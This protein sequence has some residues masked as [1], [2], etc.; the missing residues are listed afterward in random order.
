MALK[1]TGVPGVLFRE[2]KT[3]KHGVKKDR[4]FVIYYRF[5][6]KNYQEAVGWGSQG[7]N[8]KKA[9]DLLGDLKR[10]QR[11][12]ETPFTLRE[13]KDQV[14]N[15]EIEKETEALSV[16]SL[17]KRYYL[18]QAK[19]DKKTWSKDEQLF[20]LWIAPVIG[21]K[22]LH[23]VTSFDIERIKSRMSKESKSPKTI[24][25]ALAT[26]RQ[27]F[28]YAIRNELYVGKN[29]VSLVKKP[30][31]DNRRLRFLT[32]GEAL[33]LLDAVKG[34]SQQT[35]EVALLS[36]HTGGRF[37]EI[38]GLRWKDIDIPSKTITFVDTKNGES[39]VTFMT[40]EVVGVLAAKEEGKPSDL[41]FPSRVGS[42]MVGV[43]NV[44]PRTV[45]EL[46]FNDGI[47]DRRQKVVFHTMRHSFASWLVQRGIDL[48]VV[49][50]L[51]GHK[52]IKT[53][54]R[55]AHLAPSGMQ[56]AIGILNGSLQAKP[57]GDMLP[58]T[59]NDKKK[60]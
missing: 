58:L 48:L 35:Y 1:K 26:V 56:A 10:N 20:R 50:R 5:N 40:E 12:G 41:I 31:A 39:R 13:K 34:K 46:G 36:L 60:L 59:V 57:K 9:R 44:F 27:I 8:A 15:E 21:G 29:P 7:W 42:R 49:A 32:E 2:H 45:L 3:R 55:Y 28:N 16:S 6:G 38:A 23:S 22:S 54:E 11:R 24:L 43:S 33:E 37:S 51:M 14:K 52:S 18:P 53:C 17:F 47:T 30:K 4:Y 25:Y 19:Q